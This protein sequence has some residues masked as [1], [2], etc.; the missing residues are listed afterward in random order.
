MADP[1]GMRLKPEELPRFCQTALEL[2]RTGDNVNLIQSQKR[3]MP[4]QHPLEQRKATGIESHQSRADN[5]HS[6]QIG[7]R[8]N[9]AGG[10][11]PR[12][13]GAITLS[14]NQAIHHREKPSLGCF[15]E[16]ALPVTLT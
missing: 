5:I 1:I 6:S 12:F 8:N 7:S 4:G 9:Q 2:V 11:R 10:F 13:K 15:A 3:R 14:P 16:A